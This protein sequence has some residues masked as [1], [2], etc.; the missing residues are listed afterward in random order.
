MGGLDL[1]HRSKTYEIP[2]GKEDHVIIL[3]GDKKTHKRSLDQVMVT[4]LKPPNEQKGLRKQVR[5]NSFMT[6]QL[7]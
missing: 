1:Y 7:G 5:K 6:T 2:K 4:K 3:G